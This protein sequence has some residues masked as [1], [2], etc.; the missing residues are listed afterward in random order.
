MKKNC[1]SASRLLVML[2]TV[3][4]TDEARSREKVGAAAPL[5]EATVRDLSYP[6][7]LESEDGFILIHAPQI[8]AWTGFEHIEGT[9]AA[10]AHPA[11]S[12]E[13]IYATVTFEADALPDVDRRIVTV[14]DL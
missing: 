7:R 2:L 14:S 10:E 5:W 13:V 3:V 1:K 12:D 6:R 9:A 8:H 11:D 4:V